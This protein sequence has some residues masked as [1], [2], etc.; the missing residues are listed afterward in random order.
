M[1]A[2][3]SNFILG[4]FGAMQGI[5]ALMA[6]SSSATQKKAHLLALQFGGQRHAYV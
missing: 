2:Q 6:L 4:Q 1:I 3:Q 5:Y